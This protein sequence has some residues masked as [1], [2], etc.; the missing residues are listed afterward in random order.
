MWT[1]R[2]SIGEPSIYPKCKSTNIEKIIW[3]NNENEEFIRKK[4]ESG[5]KF[6]SLHK[7]LI[8]LVDEDKLNADIENEIIPALKHFEELLNLCEKLQLNY[9]LYY[10][11]PIIEKEKRQLRKKIITILSK[12]KIIKKFSEENWM[13]KDEINASIKEFTSL[14]GIHKIKHQFLFLSYYEHKNNPEI[15]KLKDELKNTITDI[16]LP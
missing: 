9:S 13:N 2:K 1:S 7:Y 14:F 11:K 5:F 10:D 15:S 12:T 16:K 4:E 8:Q 3:N 6:I